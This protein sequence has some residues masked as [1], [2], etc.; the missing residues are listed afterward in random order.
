MSGVCMVTRIERMFDDVVESSENDHART[1]YGYYSRRDYFPPR[2]DDGPIDL[3]DKE[4]TTL[5]RIKSLI[6]AV[7][8]GRETKLEKNSQRSLAFSVL[9]AVEAACSA[10]DSVAMGKLKRAV[11]SVRVSASAAQTDTERLS[12]VE[13]AAKYALSKNLIRRVA[14]IQ[15][16]PIDQERS[17]GLIE[18][19]PNI[20]MITVGR[21]KA[22]IGEMAAENIRHV[23]LPRLCHPD[24]LIRIADKSIISEIKSFAPDLI[25]FA[26][27]PADGEQEAEDESMNKYLTTALMH[28]ADAQCK[29]RFI[30]FLDGVVDDD[31]LEEYRNQIA[32]HQVMPQVLGT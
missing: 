8:S 19:N 21:G 11:C 10:V 4:E 18:D 30:L 3:V 12:N 23:S 6:S 17:T 7:S 25:L 31:D 26:A 9:R 15:S 13:I 22:P 16:Y 24:D 20:Q 5:S 1:Q 27:S 2:N 32:A 29:G 28:L 14:I